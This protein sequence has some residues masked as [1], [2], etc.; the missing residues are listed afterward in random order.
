MAQ[1]AKKHVLSSQVIAKASEDIL[2]LTMA[3]PVT[4]AIVCSIHAQGLFTLS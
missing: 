2:S 1:Q 3:G 4:A